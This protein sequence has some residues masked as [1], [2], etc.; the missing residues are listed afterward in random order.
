M[1]QKENFQ[2]L[3]C[4]KCK[5]MLDLEI[6]NEASEITEGFLYCEKCHLKFPII[7]KI[8]IILENL[9]QFLE[10]RSSLGGFLLK[11]SLTKNMKQ[12]IKQIMSQ[13]KKSN[14]DFFETEKRWTKIYLSNKN[15]PFYKSIKSH[16]SKISQKKFVIE[17][18]SS[19]GI[20]SNTLGL[21]HSHVFG[22]DTSFS[23]L[24]EAKKNSRKNCEYVLSDV[25]QHPFGEKKFD[26]IIALNL[27]ELVE[28]LSLLNTI[29]SQ[30]RNG[31]FFLSD[32]YDYD[33][34][35]NSV[36]HP[37]NEKQIRKTIH[38]KNF[39]ITKTTQV[40]SSIIWNL[41]INDRTN[42]VYKVDIIHARKSS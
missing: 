9:P 30:I 26:L 5:G 40:P 14:T 10:S 38:Q 36:K 33:R 17:Y 31:S 29:S 27:F 2:L 35:K 3:F 21:K 16:L 25:L 20:I 4:V 39:V 42:L 7:S 8:P 1:M 34:G 6:L 24:L 41:K 37:L 23:A 15:S 22:I 13:I 28:P 32:P 12:F 18:G 11:S 19:I